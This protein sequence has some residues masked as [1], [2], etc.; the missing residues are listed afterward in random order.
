MFASLALWSSLVPMKS[1]IEVVTAS[2]G[3]DPALALSPQVTVA[4]TVLSLACGV[5]LLCD[6]RSGRRAAG[7]SRLV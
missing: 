6:P 3:G 7:P 5:V 1:A 4:L 2:A